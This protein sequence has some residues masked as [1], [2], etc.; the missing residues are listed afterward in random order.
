MV[1]LVSAPRLGAFACSACA[2]GGT[3]EVT[4][5][6]WVYSCGWFV[7]NGYERKN[8][9]KGGV[10]CS[11]PSDFCGQTISIK[12]KL[13]NNTKRTNLGA[14]HDGPPPDLVG[15]RLP[16]VMYF[17]CRIVSFNNVHSKLK[18]TFWGNGH[19]GPFPRPHR[20]ALM[21]WC[22]GAPYGAFW[23][24]RCVLSRSSPY[25]SGGGSAKGGGN[26][27][28]VVVVM[29]R[30]VGLATFPSSVVTCKIM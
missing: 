29:W 15:G 25:R 3:E 21:P 11:W 30:N 28:V 17:L 19:E 20:R 26:V 6:I 8:P 23:H 5:P 1:T 9:P 18:Q 13:N 12:K 7:Q 4:H 16:L 14:G 2:G 24:L 22:P 10:F 27:W